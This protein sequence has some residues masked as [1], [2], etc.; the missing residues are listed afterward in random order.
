MNIFTRFS[1]GWTI[2]TNSF[3]VLK[4]NR[5]LIIFPILSGISMILVIASFVGILFAA[6][7]W[8]LDVATD[9]Y[10]IV[11]YI[12]VFFYY[13]VNYFV[14]VFFNTALIH[15]THL[16]FSGEEVTIRKGLQF[17]LSRIGVLLSWA[18]F[19][20][21]V[22]MALRILQDN[23]GSIGKFVTGLIGIVWSVTTFFVV[24]VIAYE[25][26]GPIA[27]FK[28][29]ASLMKEKWGE[30]LGASFSFGLI[31]FLAI[32]A[33]AVPAFLLG[34]LIH[35]VIGIIV[36]AL[37]IFTVLVVV[38]AVRTI[39]ISAVYHNINGDPVKHFN[40]QLADTLFVEK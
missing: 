21:T 30:S 16:Y 36:F 28:R 22:G 9:R 11:N 39:F 8:D 19:A 6:G 24:P 5:Q 27:A 7:R 20:A 17:S 26:L 29:S 3:S 25:N 33:M 37:G 14:I 38:S 13:L 34:W 2:A 31:Q 35:P 12:F 4:E 15:C 32:L 10:D 1:N 23:L 40:Q 18:A